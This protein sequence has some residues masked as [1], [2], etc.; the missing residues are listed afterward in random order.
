MIQLKAGIPGSQVN[1][2]NKPHGRSRMRRPG[3]KERPGLRFKRVFSDPKC[4]PFDEVEWECRTAEIT[5][6]SGKTIFKQ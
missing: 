6:D 4:A 5:D 2:G 3:G 1:K